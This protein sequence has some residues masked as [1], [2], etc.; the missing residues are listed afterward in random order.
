MNK[1]LFT[2]I[3]AAQLGWTALLSAAE[4]VDL[5]EPM[6]QSLVYLEISNSQY[7]QYQPWKQSPLSKDEGYACAVGPYEILTTAENVMNAAFLQ[8][9]CYAQNEYIPAT[10]KVV[11]YE[12]NLCLLTLDKTAMEKPLKPLRFKEVFPKGQR[13]DTYWLSS[14]GHLTTARSTLDR[15]EMRFS[16]VSFVKNLYYLATNT[17]RAF[18]DGEICCNEKDVIGMACWGTGSDSGIIPAETISRF[19]SQA[20]KETYNGFG[21]V[22]FE[23]FDLLDPTMRKYLKMPDQIKHGVYVNTVYH[24]GT[25]SK[26]LK[27]GDVILSIDGHSLNPYGRYLHDEYDRLSFEN[28]ILQK[29]DGDEI[30]FEIWRDGKKQTIEVVARNFKSEEMLVPYYLYGRQPEY[31]VVGGFV[32]QKLTRDFFSMWG[33]GWAGKVPPHLYRYYRDMAFK[34]SEQRKD[35][36]VLNYA[37]PA[38]INLGYQQLSRLVVSSLNNNKIHSLKEFVDILNSDTESDFFV[39]EFEMDSPKVIIPRAQLN[40]ENMKIAQIYGIPKTSH[41]EE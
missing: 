20:N 7:E 13:L 27:A 29:S 22:G 26:E 15:A 12:Y 3:I 32:F 4:P 10:I 33:D 25:G 41:I 28:I 31:V 9:R 6:K 11:D 38:E 39:V 34:P 18:G 30:P 1:R 35:I 17:S 23:V 40:L 14:G 16:N 8:A 19:L 21:L 5:T 36:V 24:L 2:L 37:L